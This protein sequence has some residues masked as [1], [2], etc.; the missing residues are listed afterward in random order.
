MFLK[1]AALSVLVSSTFSLVGCGPSQPNVTPAQAA[2]Y[3]SD[4]VDALDAESSILV[5]MLDGAPA[6]SAQEVANHINANAS[7]F[8]P[9]GCAKGTVT[10]AKVVMEYAGCDGPHGLSNVR[11]ELTLTFTS[12]ATAIDAHA[13]AKG[14]MMGAVTITMESDAHYEVDSGVPSMT[15]NTSGSAIGPLKTEIRRSAADAAYG[16]YKVSWTDDCI[17]L[18]GRVETTA[19][20]SWDQNEIVG[21]NYSD[22]VTSDTLLGSVMRCGGK[23]P[24]SGTVE[25]DTLGPQGVTITYDGSA[26]PA[27][28]AAGNGSTETD[29]ASLV[30]S[31]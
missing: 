17:T 9:A 29:K 16:G 6:D 12:N 25:M 27:Y 8:T 14:L 26:T 10:S 28:V 30:C 2:A 5:V 3:T 22:G 1:S 24:A 31:P 20:I 7:R 23:C 18:S 19:P 21:S 11:G 4:A 13:S 15:V